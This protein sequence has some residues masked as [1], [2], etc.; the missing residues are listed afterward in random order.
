MNYG[1]LLRD[2]ELR[3]IREDQM[4]CISQ[5]NDGFCFKLTHAY[6]AIWRTVHAGQNDLASILH[7]YGSLFLGEIKG[8][9]AH[10]CQS[11]GMENN[12]GE[13]EVFVQ[14]ICI[15]GGISGPAAQVFQCDGFC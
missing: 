1:F 7:D 12:R 8:M 13:G 11:M 15:P 10:H 5:I 14:R 9:A 4:V 2:R 6:G 3:S